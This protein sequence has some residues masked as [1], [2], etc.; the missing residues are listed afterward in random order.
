MSVADYDRFK[1]VHIGNHTDK[2][3]C[4]LWIGN[5]CGATYNELPAAMRDA[6]KQLGN[7]KTIRIVREHYCGD[8]WFPVAHYLLDDVRKSPAKKLEKYKAQQR[9]LG[10]EIAKLEKQVND[11][12][13]C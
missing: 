11:N 2:T 8:E 5:Y 1:A 10:E 12:K 7:P 3:R 9:A 4:V 6:V 13:A